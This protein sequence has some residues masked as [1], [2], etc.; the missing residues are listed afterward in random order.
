MFN[1]AGPAERA[2][3]I[4]GLRALADYLATNPAIPVPP[5][6]D[7]I[8]VHVDAAEDG[9]LIQVR[10]LARQLQAT[11]IDET[12]H[13]GHCYAARSFGPVCYRVVSIPNSR[14]AR[15]QAFWSYAGC[16]DPATPPASQP[17]FDV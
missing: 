13:D 10:Q 11:V 9:G 15:H 4:A 14:M 12:A 2:K 8:I 5:H 1:S 16:V 7:D 17:P 6:G 3:F